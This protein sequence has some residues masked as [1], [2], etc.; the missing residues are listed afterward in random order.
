MTF[1]ERVPFEDMA[2]ADKDRHQKDVDIATARNLS[3]S[4]EKHGAVGGFC[5]IFLFGSCQDLLFIVSCST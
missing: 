3:S 2:R 5:L 1:G 4:V